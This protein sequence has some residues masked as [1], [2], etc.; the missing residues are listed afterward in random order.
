MLVVS[1]DCWW[2]LETAGD[3]SEVHNVPASVGMLG[4]PVMLL[5]TRAC[6]GTCRSKPAPGLGVLMPSRWISGQAQH[7]SETPNAG[8]TG[9]LV[10]LGQE[11]VAPASVCEMATGWSV[12][13]GI[14]QQLPE[15]CL[16]ALGVSSVTVPLLKSGARSR[17]EADK[18]L[19]I[20][21]QC[22]EPAMYCSGDISKGH[23]AYSFP[24]HPWRCTPSIQFCTRVISA[25]PH[26]QGS[27]SPSAQCY[28]L[29]HLATHLH[30]LCCAL[31]LVLHPTYSVLH[32]MFLL[33]HPV[34]PALPPRPASTPAGV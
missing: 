34:C 13:Q 10:L 29:P 20:P 28:T 24:T 8:V 18:G 6:E 11:D 7:P 21:S 15:C 14:S 19:R 9:L 31:C 25:A 2:F 17:S 1:G 33:L 26:V 30:T 32:P 27:V 22:W 3:T 23:P 4:C 16:T 5:N 12:S